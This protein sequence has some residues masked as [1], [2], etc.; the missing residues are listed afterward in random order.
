[1]SCSAFRKVRLARSPL[2]PEDCAAACV[3][4]NSRAARSAAVLETARLMWKLD[5]TDSGLVDLDL[6]LPGLPGD[7]EDGPLV[8]AAGIED[9]TQSVRSFGQRLADDGG[10]AQLAVVHEDLAVARQ[11]VDGELADAGERDL[12]RHAPPGLHLHVGLQVDEEIL[13]HERERVLAGR[14]GD[15]LARRAQRL[16][17]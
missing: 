9:I 16:P 13:V 3:S 15:R 1:M 7:D 11:R 8:A 2:P 5:S 6:F 12:R 14:Q 10:R 17:S 4:E